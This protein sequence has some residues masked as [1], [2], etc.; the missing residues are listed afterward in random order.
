LIDFFFKVY[1]DW[2]PRSLFGKCSI[3]CTFI[4]GLWLSVMLLLLEPAVDAVVCDQLALCVLLLPLSTPP[5]PAL[6]LITSPCHYG[7]TVLI[8]TTATLHPSAPLPIYTRRRRYVPFMRLKG[9]VMFYCHYPDKLLAPKGGFLRR[10]YR[11]L[12]ISIIATLPFIRNMFPPPTHATPEPSSPQ[13]R[14]PFDFAEERCTLAADTVVVN[15][16]F[17]A[18]VFARAFASADTRPKGLSTPLSSR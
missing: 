9:K 17:T 13:N 6:L 18:A 2:L 4:R 14:I 10:L 1:G 12:P 15:S 11:Q 3:L 5:S 16:N 7:I 8:L